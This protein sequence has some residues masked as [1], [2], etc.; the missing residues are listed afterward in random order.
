MAHTYDKNALTFF[1]NKQN[2]REGQTLEERM[3]ELVDKVREYE[4]L[5]SDGLADRIRDLIE[6]RV[7]IPS[8]PQWS[9]FGR[10]KEEG[11]KTQPL[12]CSCNIVNYPDSIARIYYSHGEIAMLSKFGSGVGARF[13]HVSDTGTEVYTGFLSNDKLDWIDDSVRVAQKIS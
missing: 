13:L 2:I 6:R 3:T 7:F 11:S 10:P 12:N 5:Y 4:H 9:N 1:K 8:T